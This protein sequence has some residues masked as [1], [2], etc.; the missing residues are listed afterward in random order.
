MYLLE[1][2]NAIG[3]WLTH[4]NNIPIMSLLHGIQ[5][6]ILNALEILPFILFI[7]VIV[8][9][10]SKRINVPYPLLLVIAGLV[11]G[12]IPGIPNWHP[13]TDIIL[14]LFLPPIL[15][16]AARLVSSQD[17]K[18]NIVTIGSLSI[19]LVIGTALLIAF[20]LHLFIPQMTFGTALVLGA[21]ISPTDTTAAN[22][23]LSRMNIRQ[24]IIRTVEVE[25]LFNDAM[26]IVL[27]KAAILF[28]YLGTINLSHVG[29]QT[30]LV[31]LGGIAV[32]LVF[33]YFTRLIVE[34]FLFE[35]DS[36]LPIIMSLVLAYVAYMFADRVG[37]SGVLAVVAAGL[38][39]KKTE[40]KIGANARLSETNVWTT[41][42]FFLN[43]ILFISIGMQFQ[44]YLQK[45][46][47]LPTIDII[48]FSV[49]TILT[50]IVLRIVWVTLTNYIPSLFRRKQTIKGD[51]IPG[52]PYQ[53]VFIVSWS[54][55]RG[56]VSLALAIALPEMLSSTAAFPYR[57]LIIFLTLMTI[58][59]TLLVQGLTLPILIHY[60]DA[61]KDDKRELRRIAT[62][63][64]KLTQKALDYIGK[65]QE[66]QE[67]YSSEAKNLVKDYYKNR[68]L[69][70]TTTQETHLDAHEIGE[71][72]SQLLA[73]VLQYERNA[74]AKMLSKNKIS[75]EIYIRVLRKIDRDE[76]GFSAYR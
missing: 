33:A 41:L 51:K 32:G 64:Q 34:Q 10:I 1:L 22:A 52:F 42:I 6:R 72:A 2:P 14:P 65:V 67:K 24:H 38:Y 8:T 69:Q 5:D 9:S 7:V 28:V 43:G 66:D 53:K 4:K 47:Y 56:L 3:V 13:P 68:L 74:L 50:L 60:L 55:M 73:E 71:N 54:G 37:V 46:H 70:F 11:V 49:L 57:S 16:A 26:G 31:G 76:V 45:V 63:H 27:Y 75:Q 17:I 30:I 15:F 48:I 20:V 25:S 12:F 39:H 59:F 35:S 58:L 62:T 44:S 18:S 40:Q 23:I 19:G 29:G 21:I 36:E 61:G